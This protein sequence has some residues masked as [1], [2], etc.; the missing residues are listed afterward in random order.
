NS[1]VSNG[2]WLFAGAE[3]ELNI[4]IGGDSVYQEHSPVK[5]IRSWQMA[6]SN[7][8]FL[9]IPLSALPITIRLNHEP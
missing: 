5:Q 8:S 3:P 7:S 4:R 2:H 1:R 9:F 6:D